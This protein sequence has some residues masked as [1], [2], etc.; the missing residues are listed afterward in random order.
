[1]RSLGLLLAVL[2]VLVTAPPALYAAERPDAQML[3]DL[4]LLHEADPR[5]E[6]DRS[7][8]QSRPLLEFLQRV[9]RAGVERS[10]RET[11]PQPSRQEDC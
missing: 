8:S 10:R 9:E 4:D 7:V 2:T 5:L 3:L 6:R 1:M 11:A